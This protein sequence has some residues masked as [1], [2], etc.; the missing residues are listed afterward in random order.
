[1]SGIIGSAGS[2]SGVIGTTELDYEEGTWEPSTNNIDRSSGNY[3]KIGKVV[4][5]SGY[6]N[7]DGNAVTRDNFTGL[8]FAPR[9]FETNWSGVGV[10]N[11]NTVGNSVLCRVGASAS[12][13]GFNLA[14]GQFNFSDSN[15]EL[16]FTVMYEVA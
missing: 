11:Y 3:V 2:K 14:N 16:Q 12:N 13:F 8:P 7:F 9:L 6:V 5:C 15:G 1:M 4:H 10:V